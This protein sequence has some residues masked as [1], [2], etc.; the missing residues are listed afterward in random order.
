MPAISQDPVRQ[1]FIL[2]IENI[3]SH[4]FS[5]YNTDPSKFVLTDEQYYA[6]SHEAQKKLL[7]LQYKIEQFKNNLV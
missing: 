6:M 7:E 5:L 4:V 3:A 2:N 1:K